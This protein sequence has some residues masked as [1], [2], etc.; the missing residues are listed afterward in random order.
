MVI[1]HSQ[2]IYLGFLSIK[3]LSAHN[4]YIVYA[5]GATSHPLNM[6]ESWNGSH[7][8]TIKIKGFCATASHHECHLV[9]L[10]GMSWTKKMEPAELYSGD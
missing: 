6:D 10:I 5:C 1:A 2:K 7:N 8:L 9:T 3:V 4:F